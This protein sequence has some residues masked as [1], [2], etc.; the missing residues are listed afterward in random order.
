MLEFSHGYYY[1]YE[2][3]RIKPK[4]LRKFMGYFN[5]NLGQILNE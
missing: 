2:L 1:Y 4:S 5:Q 3:Y